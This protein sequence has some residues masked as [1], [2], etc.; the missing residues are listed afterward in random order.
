VNVDYPYDVAGTGRT[1]T[2]DDEAHVR[3]MI[4][5]VL[6]TSPGERVNRPDFGCGLLKM[7]FEP[8]SLEI[9]AAIQATVQAALVRW[10]SDLIDVRSVEVDSE[11]TTLQVLV[12]YVLRSTGDARTAELTRTLP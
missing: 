5:Q 7:V 6:F 11:D 8:T 3:D 10:L 12:G 4:E 1:A 9:A 2:C